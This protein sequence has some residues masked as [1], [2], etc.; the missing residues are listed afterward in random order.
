LV[1]ELAADSERSEM[2]LTV[3][4]EPAADTGAQR[5]ARDV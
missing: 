2:E 5:H 4:E 3:D 1:T